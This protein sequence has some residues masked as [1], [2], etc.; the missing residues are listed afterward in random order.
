MLR[1]TTHCQ[2]CQKLLELPGPYCV[3]CTNKILQSLMERLTRTGMPI[4]AQDLHEWE[5][6]NNL[7]FEY[8]RE[9]CKQCGATRALTPDNSSW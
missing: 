8:R 9:R 3:E 1:D 4:C 7:P 5:L 2:A 6:L